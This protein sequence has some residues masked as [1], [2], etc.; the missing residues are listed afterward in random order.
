[1]AFDRGGH[2]PVDFIAR[3][4]AL[5]P[6]PRGNFTRFHGV[7]APNNRWRGLV[8]PANGGKGVKRIAN[9]E[10][11]SSAE[12]HAAITC[13]QRIKRVF[14]IDIEVCERCGGSVSV[15]AFIEDQTIIDRILEHLREKEQ[16]ASTRSLPAP[17]P[18]APPAALPLFAGTESSSTPFN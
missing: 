4:A 11:R 18:R 16:E 12:R 3:L 9:T 8:T 6:K 7:L 5:A 15:I 14:N 2:P 1:M 17:P 10:G 13:A